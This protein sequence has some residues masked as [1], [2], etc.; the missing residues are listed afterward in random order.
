MNK[1][2]K[3]WAVIM[4]LWTSGIFSAKAVATPIYSIPSDTVI[5]R[6]DVSASSA[7]AFIAEVME[8]KGKTLFIYI[9]S[10]G[11]SVMAMER[12]INAVKAAGK[13]T[14][15][16]VDTAISAAFMFTHSACHVRI[17]QSHSLL[18][19]H[20]AS[21][22]VGGEINRIKSFQKMLHDLLDRADAIVA[23]RLK[24]TV[25]EFRRRG[26]DEWWT[27]GSKAIEEGLA[28]KEVVLRCPP[29]MFEAEIEG[30]VRTMFGP[31]A[32]T[33]S[34]CPLL[35]FPIAIGGRSSVSTH[36]RIRFMNNKEF[37]L[38]EAMFKE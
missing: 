28:D 15:C 37:Y 24:I 14:V 22:R 31:I 38:R 23:A 10:P 34:G 4:A 30:T 21:Y 26:T 8:H 36:S 3:Y 16:F 6:S 29:E 17:V 27:I 33:Y 25:A 35:P 32:V 2:V 7:S 12:M 18:M 9:D 11:G 13:K 5:F 19:S 1:L 20:Q